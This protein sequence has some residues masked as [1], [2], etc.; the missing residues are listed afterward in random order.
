MT[1]TLLPGDALAQ[2]RTLPTASVHLC[3]TSPPYH[4]QRDYKVAGQI[5]LEATW[6]EHLAALLAVV[7]EVA[8]V[9]RPDGCIWLNYGDRYASGNTSNGGYSAAST[10]AGFTNP[11][12]KGRRANDEHK[13]RKIE[14]DL[15]DKN[16]MG[17]P[18]R[19]VFALQERGWYWRSYSPWVKRNGMP[20]SAGDRPGLNLEHLFLLA[21]PKSRGRYY[22]DAEA[23]RRPGPPQNV[24]APDGWDTAPGGHGSV[25][26]NGREAGEPNAAIVTGRSWRMGDPWLDS[27]RAIVGCEHVGQA[28]GSWH[29]T[30][31]NG[32]PNRRDS[33]EKP[34]QDKQAQHG[35]RTAGFNERWDKEEAEGSAKAGPA[36]NATGGLA[37]NEAGDPL[38]LFLS[39]QGFRASD[40][41]SFPG[42]FGGV[43]HFA[44]FPE[45]LVE[46][47]I[48]SGTSAKGCCPACG[49]PWERVV[50][51]TYHGKTP[52][53]PTGGGIDSQN[54]LGE[55]YEQPRTTG[56][57]PTCKCSLQVDP[58]PCT[59]LDPFA[60][61]GTTLLVAD[62]LGRNAVGIELNATYCKIIRARLAKD[63][64]ARE[65]RLERAQ[66]TL[67]HAEDQQ[68]PHPNE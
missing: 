3:V 23:V 66:G 67:L 22:Y 68:T 43:D 63:P 6:A 61:A 58:V 7:D 30:F 10:L 55:D 49:A 19:L 11:N 29:G 45:K 51:R 34:K 56:W 60:G 25:H 16:L 57:R 33:S 26:R 4:G 48:L 21:H 15:P 42:E 5:G 40:Y 32:R 31:A 12:T 47:L 64:K 13:P 8:R 62:R 38:A 36:S 54:N 2:L 9:L 20:D 44:T 50:V 65:A 1:L 53:V 35:R 46:P 27:L 37:L 39:T 52:T 14:T 24:K 59:V 41:E 28:D 17:L 18:F